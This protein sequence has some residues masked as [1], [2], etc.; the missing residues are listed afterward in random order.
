MQHPH[1]IAFAGLFALACD[2]P[3]ADSPERAYAAAM[4]AQ[5]DR[6]DA[7]LSEM[8]GVAVNLKKESAGPADVGAKLKQLLPEAR[9]IA[10]DTAAIQPGTPELAA[11]H[12]LIVT[13][14]EDRVDV[15]ED[16]LAAWEKGDPSAANQ[17]ASGRYTGNR[18]ERRYFDEVNEILVNEGYTL[19]CERNAEGYCVG[20]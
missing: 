4:Q 5:L 18:L 17:A 9:S 11:A 16:T 10:T 15:Y 12:Q 7:M 14:W 13:A 2:A 1:L 20:Q 8:Q 6:N 3:T 19:P